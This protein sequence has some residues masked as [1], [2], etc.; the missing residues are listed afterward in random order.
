VTGPS[1]R[2]RGVY[3]GKGALPPCT[4]E[5]QKQEGTGTDAGGRKGGLTKCILPAA[6]AS[7]WCE[8]QQ[9]KGTVRMQLKTILNRVYKHRSFVYGHARWLDED[10]LTI[11]VDI[12]PRAN[13]RA[14]CSK[15]SRRRPGYDTLQPRR[16]E[17]VPLWGIVV[18]F[19][20]AMRRVDCPTCGVV[21]EAVPW[22]TGKNQLTDAYAWFLATWARRLSWAE[23][24]KAFGASWDT[25]FRA[26]KMAVEWG[27][28]NMSLDGVTA[29]GVDEI[30]W[31]KGHKYLTV[32]YQID[33]GCR[34]L[35]W[36]GQNRTI[37]TLLRF[38]RWFGKERTALI[39]FVCSDMWKAYLRVI[40][41]KAPNAL[42]ILD[43]F[44]IIQN[45][46]K[47]IDK[48][49]ADDVRELKAKGKLPILK[50]SRWVLLKRPENLNFRQ[51]V[52]LADL[53]NANL[54]TVRAYLLKEDFDLFWSYV[55]PHWA[56]RFL[57]QWCT[58]TM[59]S[60]IEPM[61]KIAKML[62]RHR[63]L[64]LNWFR[65]RGAVSTG[66]VEG[67]NN[68]AKVTTRKAYGFKSPEVAA[69]ALYHTLGKLPEPERAHR[70]C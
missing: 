51:V 29:I 18:F 65:A 46:N 53:L 59:R 45:M 55:S 47:A 58:R 13:G 10:S 20:Y 52:K 42:H 30:A 1:L 44:H 14:V 3:S 41:I 5:S 27:R 63:P 16:F 6:S 24:A 23:T 4:T 31:K 35:L 33:E 12:H 38:F 68:K 34:R 62:R 9:S 61:K 21:V 54:R 48:V 8:T 37:K 7:S 25:V 40:A 57:D 28:A 64:I 66:A 19:I 69:I 67:L 50:N 70:F 56:G 15:C 17:F 60:R 32:V 2:L 22:A 26:V 39:Q 49:R 43:R 36:V 11:E